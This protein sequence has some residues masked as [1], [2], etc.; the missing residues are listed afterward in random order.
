MVATRYLVSLVALAL[1]P[2]CGGGGSSGTVIVDDPVG[3][4]VAEGQATGDGLADQTYGELNGDDYQIVIGKTGSILAALN[5]GEINQADFALDLI[6]DDDIFQFANDLIADHDDA[7]A[8]LDAIVRS[9]GIGY[10]PSSTADSLSLEANA[11]IGELR[12]SPP[13][14]LDFTFVDLQVRMHAAAQVMLDELY[15]QV[16]PGD[17]GDFIL[18]TED[19]IDAHLAVSTDLL[20]TF[21]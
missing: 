21:Y 19:M 15:T 17:M 12:A 14:E 9:Y 3:D 7:N 10:I 1:A 6:I 4:T 11:G 13:G 8:D 5:D 18:D 20:A 16:G 2:A